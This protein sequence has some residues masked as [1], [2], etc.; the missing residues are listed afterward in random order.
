MPLLAWQVR[1]FA[2]LVVCAGCGEQLVEVPSPHR[3][4]PPRTLPTPAEPTFEL[5]ERRA[6]LPASLTRLEQQRAELETLRDEGHGH[7]AAEPTLDLSLR[8]RTLCSNDSMTSYGA[9]VRT[10]SGLSTVLMAADGGVACNL[11]SPSVHAGLLDSRRLVLPQWGARC[12][13]LAPG[14][15]QLAVFADDVRTTVDRSLLFVASAASGGNHRPDVS[16]VATPGLTVDVARGQGGLTLTPTLRSDEAPWVLYDYVPAGVEHDR[17][18]VGDCD[19]A[20]SPLVVHLLPTRG[21]KHLSLRP[22]SRGVQFDLLGERAMPAPHTPVRVAWLA[23]EVAEAY[24]FLVLPDARGEV[25]GIDQLFG[26]NTHGPEGF[27]ADGWGALAQWDGRRADG[28]VDERARDGR[29][30]ADDAVFARL[31]LWRD[32][33]GDGVAAPTELSPLADWG[34]T[35]L[36]LAADP[37]YVDEDEWGN[38]VT[39]QAWATTANGDSHVVVD[40]WLRY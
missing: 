11:S 22:P 6:L 8:V 34:L 27:A 10:A 31:R 29:I 20:E 36:S 40:V 3:R 14:R 35:A 19:R 28:S 24:A 21:T 37:L 15:Y 13:G 18:D 25:R 1:V 33:D 38:R 30:T 23:P 26:N 17:D 5:A 16:G 7:G 12:P 9:G 4:P 39:S 2:L 32:L